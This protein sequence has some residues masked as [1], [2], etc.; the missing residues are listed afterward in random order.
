LWISAQFNRTIESYEPNDNYIRSSQ[1]LLW[2]SLSQQALLVSPEE[3]NELIPIMREQGSIEAAGSVHLIIYAAPV[4]RRML[5]FNQLSYHATP[6]LPADFQAPVWLR[7]ELGLFSGRLYMEWDEYYE[8]LAYL[9]LDQDLSQH[10]E[11]PA[12]ANKPLT[13]C[14]YSR[15]YC[16]LPC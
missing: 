10:P 14:T 1:W 4:T 9:G 5:Q 13:F 3:A 11:R 16:H 2:S 6:A 7:V 12:F 8:L 15:P